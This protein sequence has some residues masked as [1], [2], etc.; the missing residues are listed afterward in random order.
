MTLLSFNLAQKNHSQSLETVLSIQESSEQIIPKTQFV[1]ENSLG[2][3]LLLAIP[4]LIGALAFLNLGKLFKP[5]P[6]NNEEQDEN[7]IPTFFSLDIAINNVRLSNY[8]KVNIAANVMIKVENQEEKKAIQAFGGA[9]NVNE[10]TISNFVSKRIEHLIRK[11][12]SDL[13]KGKNP[14]SKF[15]EKIKKIEEEIGDLTTAIKPYEQWN[16]GSDFNDLS[17]SIQRVING[18]KEDYTH[19]KETKEQLNTLIN[20]FNTTITKIDLST[21]TNDHQPGLSQ[22]FNNIN[23]FIKDKDIDK[24][25]ENLNNKIDNLSPNGENDTVFIKNLKSLNNELYVIHDKIKDINKNNS[26]PMEFSSELE[27]IISELKKAKNKFSSFEE[28]YT[29]NQEKEQTFN[30]NLSDKLKEVKNEIDKFETSETEKK[31]KKKEQEDEI[32]RIITEIE[33]TITNFKIQEQLD[34]MQKV[35]N[36]NDITM[37]ETTK[38]ILASVGL[39]IEGKIIITNVEENDNYDPN[40]LLDSLA[41]KERNKLMQNS[42]RTSRLLELEVNKIVE[43]KQLETEK[44]ISEYELEN[45]KEMTLKRLKIEQEIEKKQM[46]YDKE[47]LRQTEEIQLAQLKQ[48]QNIEEKRLEVEASIQTKEEKENTKV[49]EAKMQQEIQLAEQTKNLQII[50]LNNQQAV[51]VQ[52]MQILAAILKEETNK[53]KEEKEKLKV[54]ESIKTAIEEEKDKSRFL[55]A[56]NTAMTAEQEATAIEALAQAEGKRYELIPPNNTAQMNQII[57][58]LMLKMIET[59]KWTELAT[60]LEKLQPQLGNNNFY[61]FSADKGD[62]VNQL[63]LSSSGMLLLKTLL[64]NMKNENGTNS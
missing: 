49:E 12:I 25:I 50:Q 55:K 10:V 39:V 20:Q 2:L 60:V 8:L 11:Q 33:S 57:K 31:K 37:E 5:Q 38:N 45:E 58:E 15:D 43:I 36:I 26:Q 16:N 27:N 18:I 4:L 13:I 52:E 7:I 62:G 28:N 54:E 34:L 29:K 64:D 22:D 46:I 35:Y 61:T 63:M 9:E 32:T 53:L 40:S 42:L 48:E 14:N 19:P 23:Q 6:N 47:S 51:E 21:P 56:L 59:G 1:Q 44:K 3:S 17:E 24:L 41:I 30:D